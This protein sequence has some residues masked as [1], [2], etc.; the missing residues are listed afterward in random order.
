MQTANAKTLLVTKLDTKLG[1]SGA[2]GGEGV[3]RAIGGV[4]KL[5]VPVLGSQRCLICAFSK[6]GTW[7]M[8]GARLQL[9]TQDFTRSLTGEEV[10][11]GEVGGHGIGLVQK[12]QVSIASSRI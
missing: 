11:G 7:P 5:Q 12:L 1:G 10:G 4:Q 3:G 9:L 2:G 8:S 6:D